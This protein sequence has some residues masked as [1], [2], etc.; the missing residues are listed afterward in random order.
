MIVSVIYTLTRKR[1]IMFEAVLSFFDVNNTFFTLFGYSISY[2]EFTGTL[3]NL[4]SVILVARRSIWNW[5][6]AII[7]V[8]LFGILDSHIATLIRLVSNHPTTD[9][10]TTTPRDP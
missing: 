8:I 4:A 5:P 1:S 7:G 10:L 3:F 2:L 6:V 9:K